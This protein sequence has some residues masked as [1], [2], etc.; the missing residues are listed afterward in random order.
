MWV[1]ALASWAFPALSVT[2]CFLWRYCSP[3]SHAAALPQTES[4]RAPVR[5]APGKNR[6]ILT[7]PLDDRL[8]RARLDANH[9]T[10]GSVQVAPG[11]DI[12]GV[13]FLSLH[14]TE[15]EHIDVVA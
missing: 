10:V 14:L 1:T 3:H 6:V 4:M 11:R 12:V 5:N 7:S 15:Q 2:P 8:V 9:V 13:Q